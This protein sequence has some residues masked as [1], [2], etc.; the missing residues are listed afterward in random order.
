MKALIWYCKKLEIG[1]VKPGGSKISTT[2]ANSMKKIKEKKVLN[3]WITIEGPEDVHYFDAFEKDLKE[4]ADHFKTNKVV[5][6]PFEHFIYEIPPY[7]VSF[8]VLMELKEFLESRKYCVQLAHFGS[9]KDFKFFSPAD[10]KQVVMRTYPNKVLEN[11]KK[12]KQERKTKTK[13]PKKTFA[14]TKKKEWRSSLYNWAPS[15][16]NKK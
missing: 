12:R 15:A 8:R 13:K 14:S 11:I 9:A 1:E 3:P 2:F 10:E 4:L 7:E 5:L 6:L 16:R